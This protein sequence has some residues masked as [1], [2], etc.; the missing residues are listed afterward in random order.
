MDAVTVSIGPTFLVIGLVSLVFAIF[1]IVDMARR[2]A[3]QWARAGS[4]KSM[5]LVLEIV[6]L[7][8]VGVVSIVVG[9]L[10]LAIVRPKLAA[11]ERQGGPGWSPTPQQWPGQP[12]PWGAQP[13]GGT[14]HPGTP[15]PGG[16]PP[17][18]PGQP[19]AGPPGPWAYPGPGAPGTETPYGQPVP[20]AQTPVENP[21]FGWYED[22][23][24]RH[25]KRYWDGTRWTEHV[26]DGEA[27]STDPVTG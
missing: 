20:T 13:W 15:P 27:R 7:V 3:W 5:W 18:Y 22:P 24:G 9:I 11:A 2:P 6:T 19:P 17:A 12:S 16:G 21:P 4:N 23:S 25:E 14:P 1:V 26:S 8:L 10:Y